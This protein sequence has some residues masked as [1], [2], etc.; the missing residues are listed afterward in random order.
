M[1]LDEKGGGALEVEVWSLSRQAFGDFVA[2]IPAPLGIGKV[3]MADG[4]EL[5]GFIAEPRAAVSAQE[6]TE[7]GGWRA[8]LAQKPSWS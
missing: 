4:R 6:I 3:R 1:I 2:Q 8:Y 5:P 7:L